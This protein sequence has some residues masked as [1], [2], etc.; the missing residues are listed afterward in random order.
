M[1]I[2]I[3]QV[4]YWFSLVVSST[5]VV[6]NVMV[7]SRHDFLAA[8]LLAAASIRNDFV[9]QQPRKPLP[10]DEYR[11]PRMIPGVY[12][13]PSSNNNQ[14]E[15]RRSRTLIGIFSSNTRND[16]TYRK[17]HRELFRIW[18]DTRVCTLGELEQRP[19][20][21]RKHCQL[22]YTFVIGA[23]DADSPTQIVN[24]S[25]PLYRTKKLES[26][27]PDVNHDD[28]TLLNIK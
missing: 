9:Q 18:N 13:S 14:R 25:V 19:E 8:P 6:M 2:S 17:R 4:T 26:K 20:R 10:Q 1:M 28:V 23:G 16:C 22:V 27:F 3:K 24:A 21:E 15:Y 11:D 5:V 7:L 12:S